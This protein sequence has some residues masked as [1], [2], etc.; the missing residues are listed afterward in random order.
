MKLVGRVGYLTEVGYE[1]KTL[2]ENLTEGDHR[3]D[4][5]SCF[6]YGV[7]GRVVGS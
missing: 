1:L 2:L 4:K 3:G 6:V 7:C 5:C